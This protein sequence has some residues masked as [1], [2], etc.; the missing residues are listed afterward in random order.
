MA[1]T[2]RFVKS[3]KTRPVRTTKDLFTL[4][5]GDLKAVVGGKGISPTVT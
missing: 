3:D 1:N 4:S 5:P 2:E